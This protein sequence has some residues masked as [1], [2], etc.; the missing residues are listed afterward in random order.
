MEI[1]QLRTLMHVAETGS[2]SKASDRLNIAQPAL[3]RQIRMLEAEL[4]VRL[5]DRH[6]R[7][8]MITEAGRE[9]LK[10]AARIMTEL[11]EI[12][13]CA[14]DASAPLKG[15]IS[16]GLPPTVSEIIS[17]PLIEEFRKTH[18]EVTVGLSSAYSGY[19]LDWLQRG[20]IDIAVLYDP[21]A[22]RVLRS[23]PLLQENLF[24]IGPADANFS[25]ETAMPFAALASQRLLLP[26]RGHGLRETV[27]RFAAECEVPLDVT[28]EANSF[29]TLKDLVSNGHGWTIL[30]FAP[31]HGDVMAGRLS[32]APLVDPVPVR[33]LVLAYLADRPA[34]RLA[35][36]AGDTIEKIATDL[37]GRGIWSGKLLVGEPE[38]D[39][40]PA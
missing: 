38:T 31:I 6:G 35:R 39:K 17:V 40:I 34:T 1:A 21:R 37:I 9:V 16:I 7:G 30:P 28:V 18:P 36:F 20:D 25:P 5:F 10:R 8:M 32:A 22:T 23:R 14:G 26:S 2:L 3:G 24:V 19:V 11:D 29:N 12:K 33:R 15:N 27:E 13:A 4:G